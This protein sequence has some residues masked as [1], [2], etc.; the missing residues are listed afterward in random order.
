MIHFSIMTGL[1]FHP[2]IGRERRQKLNNHL[3]I[4]YN[5]NSIF[6]IKKERMNL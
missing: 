6:L 2:R 3:I 4:K 5:L 1:L